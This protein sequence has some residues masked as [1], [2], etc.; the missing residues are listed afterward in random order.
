M[1]G[2]AHARAGGLD[3]AHGPRGHRH[4]RRGGTLPLL[5]A[6]RS[7]AFRG[8]PG[9]GFAGGG[10][11]GSA[12]VAAARRALRGQRGVL[13]LLSGGGP[14]GAVLTARRRK[15]Q[16]GLAVTHRGTESA[17]RGGPGTHLLQE[18]VREELLERDALHGVAPQQLV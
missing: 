1:H 10:A 13:R 12:A 2:A 14:C 3:K 7:A 15:V 4:V 5:L 8:L 17:S 18:G 11:I 9:S 6:G 16:A